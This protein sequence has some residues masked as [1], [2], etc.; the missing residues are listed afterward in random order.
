MITETMRLHSTERPWNCNRQLRTAARVL[1]GACVMTVISAG[2]ATSPAVDSG[3]GVD[4]RPQPD[5]VVSANLAR[6]LES[7]LEFKQDKELSIYLHDVAAKLA[8]GNNDLRLS[9]VG[10]LVVADQG[11]VWQDFGIPGN[12]V[13]LSAGLL[14]HVEYE[15]ELAAAIA[16]ELSHILKRHAVIRIQNGRGSLLASAPEY[17]PSIEGLVPT[18]SDG[19]GK[20]IDFFSPTGVFAYPDEYNL[21]AVD[22]AVDL[23]YRA[24]FDPRGLVSL[25]EL[26]GAQP[27]H[28]PYEEDLLRKLTE[29]TRTNIARHSPLRNPIVRSAAFLLIRER[30]DKL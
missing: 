30:I 1:L 24:G 15:N 12:R 8:D 11:R 3:P 23:L 13:Y 25:W 7:R 18:S 5:Q 4:P 10:V 20:E 2:C 29:R 6:Q 27:A 19:A 28:S 26:Y 9:S 21:E 14:K 17:F 22:G 16:F